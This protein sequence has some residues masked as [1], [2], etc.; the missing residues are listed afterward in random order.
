MDQQLDNTRDFMAASIQK[1]QDSEKK[2]AECN[3]EI[4]NLKEQLRLTKE[5]LNNAK[6]ATKRLRAER[7]NRFNQPELVLEGD[8]HQSQ[9][10]VSSTRTTR[11]V[12]MVEDDH[13][14]PE[15]VRYVPE[16]S[17]SSEEPRNIDTV[18]SD[19]YYSD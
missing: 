12:I 9:L 4:S 14:N 1:L 19:A 7:R 18:Y 15:Q 16:I 3:Q 8:L 17:S 5:L 2:V 13:S 6:K 10:T 11:N